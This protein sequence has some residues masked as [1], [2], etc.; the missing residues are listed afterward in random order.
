[1]K[2]HYFTFGVGHSH[3]INGV[4]YDGNCVLKVTSDDPRETMFSVFGDK[5]CLEHSEPPSLKY[6]PRGILELPPGTGPGKYDDLLTAA[7][8]SAEAE[9]GI[10]IILGG[11]KGSGFSVQ[12]SYELT[13]QLP[14][15]LRT[16]ATQIERATA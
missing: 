5:W 16:V 10:L 9:G 8:E 2:T 14:G 4:L 12:G 7:R 6:Y 15:M 3:I 1:M 13:K 11:E